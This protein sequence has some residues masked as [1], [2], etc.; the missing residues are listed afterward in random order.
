MRRP[1]AGHTL[2]HMQ[3][4]PTARPI[5]I[6][7]LVVSFKTHV[8]NLLAKLGVDNRAQAMVQAIKRGLVSLDDMEG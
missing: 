2:C 1:A 6:R 5:S 8:A 3:R 7:R 4:W